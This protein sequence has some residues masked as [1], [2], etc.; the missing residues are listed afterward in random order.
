MSND[1]CK[2]PAV[3][4][5]WQLAFGQYPSE[6]SRNTPKVEVQGGML[7]VYL[8]V[9]FGT[10]DAQAI[11]YAFMP[12]ATA[13]S[14]NMQQGIDALLLL[15]TCEECLEAWEKESVAHYRV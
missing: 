9:S 4:R 2:G 3:K 15:D 12:W 6:F 5:E 13:A 7:R 10:Q 11:L 1:F 14:N 8:R